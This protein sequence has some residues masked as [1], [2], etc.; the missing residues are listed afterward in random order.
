MNTFSDKDYDSSDG[1]NVNFWGKILWTFLHTISFNYPVSPTE[2]D[3][4]HYHDFL[5]SL[6]YVIPCKACRENYKKNLELVGYSRECLRDRKSFSMFI[7]MLHNCV[8]NMLGKKCPLTYA[9]VRDRYELFRARCINNVPLVSKHEG[10]ELGCDI[11]LFG[12]KSKSVISVVPIDLKCNV[13]NIDP[14][15]IP[16]RKK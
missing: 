8:N 12:V 4:D 14:K 9:Q 11:P 15:C 6:K 13:F 5:M 1:M 16:K 2:E 10:K 3:K 7:Y